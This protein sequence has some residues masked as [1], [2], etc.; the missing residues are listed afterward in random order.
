MNFLHLKM[1]TFEKKYMYIRLCAC[2]YRVIEMINRTL[3]TPK[4]LSLYSRWSWLWP[5]LNRTSVFV[6]QSSLIFKWTPRYLSESTISMSFPWMFTG[7]VGGTSSWRSRPSL[8]SCW[9]WFGERWSHTSGQS[10]W[11]P[12]YILGRSHLICI[13]WCGGSINRELLYVAVVRVV[14]EV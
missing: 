13:R 2:V 11:W 6:V 1:Y 14:P 3:H 4:D 8:S 10:C 5:F 7:G 12:P 9:R